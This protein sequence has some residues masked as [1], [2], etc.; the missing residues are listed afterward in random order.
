LPKEENM[1]ELLAAGWKNEELLP[2][3]KEAPNPPALPV[4]KGLVGGGLRLIALA[5]A[6][7]TWKL[8]SLL[9]SPSFPSKQLRTTL[10][11]C[12]TSLPVEASSRRERS[13]A[14][15]SLNSWGATPSGAGL[16]WCRASRLWCM[17]YTLAATSCSWSCWRRTNSRSAVSLSREEL[18]L[19]LRQ[20]S[21]S[22]IRSRQ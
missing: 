12:G 3:L 22:S 16:R 18:L 8:P 21:T 1:E 13:P 15:D 17:E 7:F 19:A 6:M 14:A 5:L 4:T 2:A 10:L 20:L 9:P 11:P